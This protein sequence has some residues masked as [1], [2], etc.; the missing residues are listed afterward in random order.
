[1]PDKEKVITDLQIIH[2]WAEFALEKDLNFFE[3]PHIQDIKDWTEDAIVLIKEQEDT[4]CAYAELLIKHGYKFTDKF[5]KTIQKQNAEWIKVDDKDDAFDC[6]KCGAMVK[7]KCLYCPGCGSKMK[8]GK[9]A[10]ELA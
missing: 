9:R 5:L 2:T 6:S 3:K 1:M 7:R 10:I 8:N 4:I